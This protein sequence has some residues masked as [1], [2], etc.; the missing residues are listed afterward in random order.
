MTLTTIDDEAWD[1]LLATPESQAFLDLLEEEV[2][3]DYRAGRTEA[4]G[5]GNDHTSLTTKQQWREPALQLMDASACF[6]DAEK[7]A[8]A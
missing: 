2:L 3:Q 7:G 8:Q 6:S 1:K 4:G 5:F